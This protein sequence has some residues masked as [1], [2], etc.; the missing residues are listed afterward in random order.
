MEQTNIINYGLE[1]EISIRE[2]MSKCAMM[3][4]DI[5]LPLETA[6]RY[7]KQYVLLKGLLLLAQEYTQEIKNEI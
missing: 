3:S 1:I 7:K 2:Q 4:I 5:Y 6:L